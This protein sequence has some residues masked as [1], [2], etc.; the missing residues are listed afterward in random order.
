LQLYETS[1]TFHEEIDATNTSSSASL[2]KIYAVKTNN[3]SKDAFFFDEESAQL[4][5]SSLS[6]QKESTIE[7][8]R[9]VVSALEFLFPTPPSA[10]AH[11][12][13]QINIG[14]FRGVGGGI[15]T[16][17]QTII[18]EIHTI[19]GSKFDVKHCVDTYLHYLHTKKKTPLLAY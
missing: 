5:R 16:V 8:F 17:S 11:P 12:I 14:Y 18:K 3:A 4:Y 6:Q 9:D 10:T 2:D 7:T 19:Y 1:V 15:D 13:H